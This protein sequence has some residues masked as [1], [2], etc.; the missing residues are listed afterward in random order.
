MHFADQGIDTGASVQ[1]R[2]NEVKSNLSSSKETE[3]NES[4]QSA[5]LLRPLASGK[6]LI[7]RSLNPEIQVCYAPSSSARPQIYSVSSSHFLQPRQT[8][9][10]FVLNV[11]CLQQALV[12]S[13]AWSP[14]PGSV[15]NALFPWSDPVVSLRKPLNGSFA[16]FRNMSKH[17]DAQWSPRLL[18]MPESGN[19]CRSSEPFL[20]HFPRAWIAVTQEH[21]PKGDLPGEWQDHPVTHL[22]AAIHLECSV[23]E[24]LGMCTAQI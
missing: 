3:C 15:P 12:I 1:P 14:S 16:T 19:D 11:C 13:R 21:S 5:S 7:V 9:F 6:A 8:S 22:R 18:Q 10:L 2:V 4:C 23:N 20:P 17:R 24:A